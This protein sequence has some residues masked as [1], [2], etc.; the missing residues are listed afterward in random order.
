[1][2]RSGRFVVLSSLCRGLPLKPCFFTVEG[3]SDF[4]KNQR[5]V[6]QRVVFRSFASPLAWEGAQFFKTCAQK[7]G[8]GNMVYLGE[9]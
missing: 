5:V 4:F 3:L 8:S 1:M 7:H 6:G 2:Q 9:P